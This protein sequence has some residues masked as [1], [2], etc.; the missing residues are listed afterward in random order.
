MRH[1]KYFEKKGDIFLIMI[2]PNLNFH[3]HFLYYI[4]SIFPF[5]A[6]VSAWIVFYTCGHYTSGLVLTIS[7]TMCPFPENRIFG[8]SMNIESIL[9]FIIYFIRIKIIQKHSELQNSSLSLGYKIRM[10]VMYVCL[11]IVPIGLCA[12][13]AVTLDDCAPVHLLGAA[14]FFYGSLIFY[15]VSDYSIKA[16]NCKV[17]LYSKLTTWAILVFLFLYMLLLNVSSK[18]AFT[19]AGAIFQYLTALS[20]F[21]KI[22]SSNSI[23][24]T[25]KFP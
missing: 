9:L 8:C 25:K 4:S 17:P 22:F 20:I 19:N 7:E 3:L 21:I 15:F 13:S 24:A 5:L 10:I 23:F 16:V 12:L 18:T 1:I 2:E 6:V 14:F 11:F